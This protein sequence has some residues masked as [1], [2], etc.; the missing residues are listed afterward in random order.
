MLSDAILSSRSLHPTPYTLPVHPTPHTLPVHPTPYTPS[1]R[2][3]GS[4]RLRLHRTRPETEGDFCKTVIDFRLHS[5]LSH[6]PGHLVARLCTQLLRCIRIR[7]HYVYNC[8]WLGST[9]KLGGGSEITNLAWWLGTAR[10]VAQ[11][12]Y[13]VRTRSLAD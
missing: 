3:P 5:F 2:I 13:S 11:K 10:L 9:G 1:S 4:R 6:H 7:T 8:W 12:F